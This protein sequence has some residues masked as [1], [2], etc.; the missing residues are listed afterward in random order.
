[1]LQVYLVRHGETEWNALRR[2]QGQSDSALTLNGERQALQVA[3]RAKVLGINHIISSDLGR[4]RHTAEIIAGAC[5]CDVSLDPRLRE[6]DMGVLEM[7]DIDTLTV[8]EEGWRKQLVDG[9]PDGR[10]PQ[11]ES[12]T[13]L[14][15][16][17]Q[18]VLD[19][20]RQLPPG[21]VP[22]LVSHGMALGCLISTVLGLPPYAER[23]LRLRNCSLSRMDFQQSPWLA[24]G[25]VV[26][27]A[28]DISH[29]DRPALDE[30][31]R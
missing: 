19:D 10:I 12:M 29:L 21:S 9:T 16:R 7:R 2:I 5:G 14:A 8:E 25:W 15:R 11:G 23:R 20:C 4:T 18:A 1:M 22:L 31:Q 3:A 28:G 24:P 27:T 30:L 17:M 6:L 13:E 26:E